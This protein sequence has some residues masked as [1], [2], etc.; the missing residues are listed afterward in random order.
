MVLVLVEITGDYDALECVF[1]MTQAMHSS[2]WVVGYGFMHCVGS[3]SGR[4]E[5]S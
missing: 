2:I 4:H 5:F 3:E 1:R